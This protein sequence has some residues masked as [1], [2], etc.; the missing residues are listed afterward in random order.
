MRRAIILLVAAFAAFSAAP[1]R[2]EISVPEGYR[3]DRRQEVAPGV[4]HLTFSHRDPPQVVHVARLTP[5]ARVTVRTMLSNGLVSGA[6]AGASMERTSAMCVRAGCILGVNGD[7]YFPET[8]EPVGGLV[9]AGELIRSP[10]QHHHQLIFDGDG[11]LSAGNFVW[12]AALV[13]TDLV[14]TSI[15]A[16]NSERQ[17]DQIVLYTPKFG[18]STATNRFGVELVGELLRP[19]P[20]LRLGQT[21]LVRLAGLREGEGNAPIPTGGLVLSGHGAGAAALTDLWTRVQEGTASNEVLLRIES[22]PPVAES[23]GGT[24]ILVRE[25]KLWFD[26]AANTFVRGRHPRTIVG[27]N[28]SGE[29]LLVTVDGRQP[30]YAS[31]MSL[32]EAANL[33]IAFGATE[34][35][36]L[37]GGGSTTF[38]LG[39]Q[40][41]NRP[42]DR[43]VRRSGGT[44]IVAA[45]GRGDSVLGNVERPVAVALLVIPEQPAPATGF[46]MG[47]D[48]ELPTAF[49]MPAPAATDPGSVPNATLPILVVEYD[50]K[51]PGLLALAVLANAAVA[52]A[53]LRKLRL[54]R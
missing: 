26:N 24:P 36:N 2:A 45:P 20:P 10:S 46:S 11:A 3:L 28:Q 14:Q 38:V 8:G 5:G 42:S 7:F 33:M 43:A 52:A 51:R 29:V 23:L 27:W 44:D 19:P 40:V 54:G 12:K 1:V 35:L 50:S 30:G 6:G 22:D 4:E 53:F 48:I 17:A 15:G 31:G 41:V 39:G 21:S 16:L 25:G 37:D 9:S 32:T 34:A 18:A 47:D 49:A 13:S